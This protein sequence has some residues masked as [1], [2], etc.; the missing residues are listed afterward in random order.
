MEDSFTEA[1]KDTWFIGSRPA[2]EMEFIPQNDTTLI[3]TPV[4]NTNAYYVASLASRPAHYRPHTAGNTDA[5]RTAG[6]YVT[7]YFRMTIP[8]S[9]LSDIF[10]VGDSVLY[11]NSLGQTF[12]QIR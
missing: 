5:A 7:T 11:F 2:L 1:N 10:N 4:N 6:M 12:T 9:Y 3:P 8:L